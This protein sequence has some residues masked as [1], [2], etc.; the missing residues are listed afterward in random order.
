[1]GITGVEPT[2]LL[3]KGLRV[4]CLEIRQGPAGWIVLIQP[5][6]LIALITEPQLELV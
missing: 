4:R 6:G 5:D 1:M 3:L 2:H